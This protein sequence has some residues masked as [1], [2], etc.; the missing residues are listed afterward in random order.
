MSGEAAVFGGLGASATGMGFVFGG[1]KAQDTVKDVWNQVK[2]YVLYA[3]GIF[4]AF[5]IWL[6]HG[7]KTNQLACCGD[8]RSKLLWISSL[9]EY[10]LYIAG[11]GI[12]YSYTTDSA[13]FA[14][15]LV[16]IAL[17]TSF[18]VNQIDPFGENFQVQ[19]KRQ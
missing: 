6:F 1:E 14:A 13:V 9:M 8:T 17:V 4:F 15:I 2:L 18:F 19:D 16:L 3:G 10:A 11:C 5:S 7:F 12:I